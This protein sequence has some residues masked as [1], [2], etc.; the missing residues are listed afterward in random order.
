MHV[1][2]RQQLKVAER[3]N[4]GGE[5]R[6]NPFPSPHV[7]YWLDRTRAGYFGPLIVDGIVT[8]HQLFRQA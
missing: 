3:F 7:K 8:L 4:G 1:A 5:F 2:L 6:V